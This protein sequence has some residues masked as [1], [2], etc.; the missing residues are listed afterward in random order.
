M[1]IKGVP[2]HSYYKAFDADFFFVLLTC[3]EYLLV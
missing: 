1:Y 3:T 2:G